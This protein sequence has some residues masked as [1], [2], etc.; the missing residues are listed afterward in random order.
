MLFVFILYQLHDIILLN[1]IA[2]DEGIHP[3]DLS[4]VIPALGPTDLNDN[5]N[6][7]IQGPDLS[8]IASSIIRNQPIVSSSSLMDI[9]RSEADRAMGGADGPMVGPIDNDPFINLPDELLHLPVLPSVSGPDMASV[10][11]ILPGNNNVVRELIIIIMFFM[12]SNYALVLFYFYQLNADV[13]SLRLLSSRYIE[14]HSNYT[15]LILYE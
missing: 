8:A 6:T 1:N 4:D 5:T 9:Q 15:L 2:I 7:G 12:G 10:Q 11:D 14:S 3:G 13:G